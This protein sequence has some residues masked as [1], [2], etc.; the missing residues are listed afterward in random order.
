M[1][2]G[3]KVVEDMIEG[4]SDWMDEKGYTSVD[5]VVGRA[6]PNASDWQHLNL[7]Y[8]AKAKIDQDLCI[9]VRPL[10]HCL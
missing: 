7:N 6:V 3:F 10:P 9:Q 1:T 4:L 8:I 2:Y 5:Q